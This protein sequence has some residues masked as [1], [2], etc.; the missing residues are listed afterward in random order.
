MQ[1]PTRR[2]RTIALGAALVAIAAVAF[3]PA[4]AQNRNG[5]PEGRASEF[6]PP[7]DGRG[8]FGGPPVGGIS[9]ERLDRELSFTDTQKAQI[10][11][12][13]QEQ[14]TALKSTLDAF[15][16]AQQALDA[17]VM[18]MPSDAGLLQTRATELSTIQAQMLLARAQTESKIYQLLT[19]E[20][21][22]KAQQRLT[23]MQQ[24]I[25][26]RAGHSGK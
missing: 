3:V 22:Q 4:I 10:Q 23:Q 13:L 9:L 14:R 6:G 7:L 12:L 1:S 19:A 21:Q 11:T 25:H 5:R 2:I 8:A 15:R 16:Q 20:Q 17:A 18:Q 24:R 26:Q